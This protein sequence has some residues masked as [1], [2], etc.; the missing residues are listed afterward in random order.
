MVVGCFEAAP[1]A[2]CV[3]YSLPTFLCCLSPLNKQTTL[4]PVVLDGLRVNQLTLARRLSGEMALTEPRLLLKGRG[5][6]RRGD[7][8]LELD[9]ALPPSPLATRPAPGPD[10]RL[11]LLLYRPPGFAAA[12]MQRQQ[13]QAVAVQ[14]QQH[15][16]QQAA[17][18]AAAASQQR[19]AEGSGAGGGEGGVEGG[20]G[21]MSAAEAAAAAAAAEAAAA[22]AAIE[23]QRVSHVLLRRGDLHF[24]STVRVC[25]CGVGVCVCVFVVIAEALSGPLCVCAMHCEPPLSCKCC[26]W[27]LYHF[28]CHPYSHPA[29]R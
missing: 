26:C 27:S 7:E 8:L 24:S 15:Q 10:G 14:Q 16:Q 21:G 17:A 23:A 6:G 20:Y 3:H 28:C 22:A 18:A 29:I 11:P 25:V 12:H 2:L 9:L 5:P 4:G 13:Q 19:Q 1:S